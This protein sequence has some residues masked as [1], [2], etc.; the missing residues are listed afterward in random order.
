[1]NEIETYAR[2]YTF[3]MCLFYGQIITVVQYN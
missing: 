3:P 1:M 2:E